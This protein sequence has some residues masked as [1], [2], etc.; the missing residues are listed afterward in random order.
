VETAEDRGKQVNQHAH[1]EDGEPGP[2]K[3]WEPSEL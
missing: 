3:E 2:G 1:S